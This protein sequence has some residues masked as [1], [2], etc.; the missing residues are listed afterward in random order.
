[1]KRRKQ[2]KK[3]TPIIL[4]TRNPPQGNLAEQA[5]PIIPPISSP[6]SSAHRRR[7]HLHSLRQ[8]LHDKE[9]RPNSKG[10]P[11][12][13]NLP[14]PKQLLRKIKQKTKHA[15]HRNQNP[16]TTSVFLPFWTP[17]PRSNLCHSAC[18]SCYDEHARKD[19]VRLG[20]QHSYCKQCFHQL[21]LSAL[22][23]EEDWPPKCCVTPI[24]HNTCLKNIP[25]ALAAVYKQKWLE[26]SIPMNQRYYCPAP[27]CG[28]FVPADKINAPYRRARCKNK[29][30]TC[31]D[32]RGGAHVDAAKCPRNRDM[33]LVT[34]MGGELG[35][36]RCWRC[37][38]MIEHR[39]SCRHMR[40]RCGAEFCFV[41]GRKWWTCG[42]TE[43][44]LRDLKERVAHD[45]ETRRA[46]ELRQRARSH[47]ERQDMYSGDQLG[48]FGA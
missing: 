25:R 38:T 11:S 40:C 3:G 19:L 1:M 9:S 18:L 36:R 13:H 32:C 23:P 46:E 10:H 47:W 15:L 43:R 45:A 28:I 5:R 31:M 14:E 29:H 22:Q 4:P 48:G 16:E 37:L 21:V 20:C 33:E 35:W 39:N 34:R 24:D 6:P 44:Q 27:D 30:L 17:D 26:Y 7:L 12:P 41:C 42:C 2:A 8:R